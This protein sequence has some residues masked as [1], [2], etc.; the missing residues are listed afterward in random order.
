MSK[1]MHNANVDTFPESH[2][3]Q[4]F[5]AVEFT[6]SKSSKIMQQEDKRSC[7]RSYFNGAVRYL[8]YT[9]VLLS[10]H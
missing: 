5:L 7:F 1:G 4:Y 10:K 8:G 3:V 6:H 9:R 2:L